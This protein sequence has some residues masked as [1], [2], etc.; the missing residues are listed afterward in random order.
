MDEFVTQVSEH[1]HNWNPMI[2]SLNI[3]EIFVAGD[4]SVQLGPSHIPDTAWGLSLLDLLSQYFVTTVFKE[5]TIYKIPI[6]IGKY[7]DDAGTESSESELKSKGKM[8]QKAKKR[9][10]S[11]RIKKEPIQQS[12]KVKKEA[13][14]L[15]KQRIRDSIQLSTQIQKEP[16]A[17]LVTPRKK[18]SF[19]DFQSPDVTAAQEQNSPVTAEN[20]L[21]DTGV[22]SDI[23]DLPSLKTLITDASTSMAVDAPAGRTRK[24]QAHMKLN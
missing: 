6:F 21:S 13:T 11:T 20:D 18:R 16:T 12:I 17:E 15:P 8:V 2:N 4:Y 23:P 5:K 7:D 10:E 22:D 3:F 9:K 19:V 24:Q 14:E 1:L